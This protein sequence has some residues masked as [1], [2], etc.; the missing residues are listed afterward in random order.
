[1]CVVGFLFIGFIQNI[2]L[3]CLLCVTIVF[4]FVFFVLSQWLLRWSVSRDVKIKF[5]SACIHIFQ[6][7]KKS[8][9]KFFVVTVLFLLFVYCLCVHNVYKTLFQAP[10]YLEY[11]SSMRNIYMFRFKKSGIQSSTHSFLNFIHFLCSV[12]ASDNTF[13]FK[14]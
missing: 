12:L 1:M 10:L 2:K 14:I 8:R 7:K 11:R 9:K 4:F 6:K 5:M 13:K 3:S